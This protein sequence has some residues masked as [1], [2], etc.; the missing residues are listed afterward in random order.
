[1]PAGTHGAARPRPLYIPP[2]DP[3]VD[4]LEYSRLSV[5]PAAVQGTSGLS[6]NTLAI[7]AALSFEQLGDLNSALCR[8]DQVRAGI[9]NAQ[10]FRDT[11]RK[12]GLGLS[13]EGIENIVKA[14][15]L[16]R[17][18]RRIWWNRFIHDMSQLAGHPAKGS[19]SMTLMEPPLSPEASLN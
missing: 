19:G 6:Q 14:Y 3:D 15:S 2:S 16:D 1:M 8:L 12:Q 7:L 10:P 13:E 5:Q 17:H 18:D 11:V 4:N 9:V